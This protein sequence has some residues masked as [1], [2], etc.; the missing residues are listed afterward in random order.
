MKGAPSMNRDDLPHVLEIQLSDRPS[1]L[2]VWNNLKE[3]DERAKG[4]E[5]RREDWIRFRTDWRGIRQRVPR[6][7]I[8]GI[9]IYVAQPEHLVK[10]EPPPVEPKPEA[11]SDKGNGTAAT[12]ADP[13]PKPEEVAN[14]APK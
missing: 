12:V 6:G 9:A 13:K 4:L 5:G 1:I 11:K 2:T 3:A 7:F 10:L 14:E 8:R